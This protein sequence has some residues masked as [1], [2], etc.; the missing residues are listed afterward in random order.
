MISVTGMYSMALPLAIDLDSFVV[1]S[2]CMDLYSG[3]F[4][5]L[6]QLSPNYLINVIAIAN[7][8]KV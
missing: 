1:L 2:Y 6:I 8:V 4:I 5:Q 7:N 3:K